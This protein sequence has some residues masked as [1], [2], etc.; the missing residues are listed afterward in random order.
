M[1]RPGPAV[2]VQPRTQLGAYDV[3]SQP[4]YAIANVVV[5]FLQCSSSQTPRLEATGWASMA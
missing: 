2:P 4:E 5:C 3:E 1:V